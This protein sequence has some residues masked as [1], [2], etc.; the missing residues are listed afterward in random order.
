MLGWTESHWVREKSAPRFVTKQDPLGP[1]Q[2]RPFP[3]IICFSSSLKCNLYPV[4]GLQE[5]CALCVQLQEQRISAQISL[6]QPTTPLSH[7][8]FRN[9][10]QFCFRAFRILEGH[11]PPICL[12]GH[13]INLSM[14][15][16]PMV[17]FVW[18]PCTQ[19]CTNRLTPT[20]D[21]GGT[22]WGGAVIKNYNFC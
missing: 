16:T 19:S 2:G 12:H 9:T 15:Q 13:A 21:E 22:T 6:Q 20:W 17:W 8:A 11:K 3:H 7:F 4:G 14:L 1:S 5:L 10:L 18:L